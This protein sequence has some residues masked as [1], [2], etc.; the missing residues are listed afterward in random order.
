MLEILLVFIMNNEPP[1]ISDRVFTSYKECADFVNGLVGQVVQEDYTFDFV[2]SDGQ[3]F[4][5]ICVDKKDYQ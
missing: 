2:S 3:R 4:S 5:G 1:K